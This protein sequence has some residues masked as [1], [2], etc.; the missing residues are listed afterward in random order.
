[1]K[2]KLTNSDLY[3][4]YF[5]KNNLQRHYNKHVISDE[6]G[7]LKMEYMSP[8]EYDALADKLSNAQASRLNDKEADIIGYITKGGRIIKHDKRNNLTVVY[9]DDDI[10][11]HEAIALYKQR[12]GKFFDRA[13]KKGSETEFGG[14]IS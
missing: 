1:M 12:T 6:D 13:N 4:V 8:E 7:Y 2:F 5:T 11:G 9:V 10:N 3:E 14:H